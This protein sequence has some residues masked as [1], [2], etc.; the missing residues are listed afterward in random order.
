MDLSSFKMRIRIIFIFIFVFS[1]VLMFRLFSIQVV[2]K[3]IYAEKADQQYMTL[4]GEVFDRGLIFFSK[5]DN[6]LVS[7]ATNLMGFKIAL[8]TSKV[9]DPEFLYQALKPY[10][11]MSHE[12]FIFHASKKDDP[13]EEI[14]VG[15]NK[16]QISEIQNLKLSGVNFYRDNWRFYPGGDLASQTI[17]FLAYKEDDLIGQYGLERFYENILSKPKDELY[18]NFFAEVF[19]NIRE[20]IS[21]KKSSQGDLVTTI[22]PIVQK[23]LESELTNTFE[24]WKVDQAGGIIINPLNGQIYAIASLPNF[25][26]N[27]FRNVSD[28]GVFRH[29]FVEN[30]FEFGSV[31]K[32][33]VIASA[34]DAGVL[35]PETTYFDHGFITVD[36]KQIYNFDKKGRGLVTMQE[37]LN[38]SLNTGMVYAESKLGH[39]KFRS[40]LKSFGLGEKTGVD[41]PNEIP[42]LI[43]NLDSPRNIEYANASFGQGIALTPIQLVRALSSLANGGNLIT[44]HFVKKIRYSNGKIKDIDYQIEKKT[45]V[46][47]EANETISR[48]LTG[49]FESYGKGS[50]KI[51]NYSI[52]AKTGTAQV[53]KKDGRGYYDD[54]NMHSFFAYFPAYEPQFLV[55]LYL[56]NPK[57]VQYASQSLIPVF[58]NLTNF[59]INYY[60]VPPDR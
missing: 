30:V 17:G 52:A 60:N 44:P 55:F 43:K 12:K 11:K 51:P 23:T 3:N 27:N 21:S 40:Y 8:N 53:A 10:I 19:S 49:A 15:L 46:K 56:E 39:D 6:S 1:I 2:N 31:V 47:K 26:L 5:K 48:M 18:L 36:K 35:T 9:T 59:L 42:G 25:D 22:E 58:M 14:Q 34:I 16:E 50:Y 37:V 32:P 28:V 20:N 57:G 54:R 13:Y 4:A 33:L 41:L 24:K 29:P 38:Q 45:L 7:A